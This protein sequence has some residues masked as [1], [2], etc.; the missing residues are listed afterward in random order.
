MKNFME[1]VMNAV[2]SAVAIVL[3]AFCLFAAVD[4]FVNPKPDYGPAEADYGDP[5][6]EVYIKYNTS[7]EY[8]RCVTLLP[9]YPDARR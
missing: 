1:T 6:L 9:V 5:E 7:K 4:G 8:A 3:I 2:F